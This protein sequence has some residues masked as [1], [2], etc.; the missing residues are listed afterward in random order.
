M[1]KQ[2]TGGML[3]STGGRELGQQ[4]EGH[5]VRGGSCLFVFKASET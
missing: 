3:L 1:N 4:L 5:G 2:L